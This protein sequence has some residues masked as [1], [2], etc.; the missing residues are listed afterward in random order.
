ML[1]SLETID[2]KIQ[3]VKEASQLD[4]DLIISHF[5]LST[6]GSQEVFFSLERIILNDD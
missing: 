2:Y 1:K 5:L 3:S 6:Q 4:L